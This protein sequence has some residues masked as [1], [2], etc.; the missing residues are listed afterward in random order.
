[1]RKTMYEDALEG[2][3]QSLEESRDNITDAI[4]ALLSFIDDSLLCEKNPGLQPLV[5]TLEKLI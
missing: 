3:I 5:D 2:K 4:E 1:M